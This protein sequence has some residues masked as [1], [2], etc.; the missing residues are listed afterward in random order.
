MFAFLFFFVLFFSLSPLWASH[1]IVI[2]TITRTNKNK[3]RHSTNVT[4]HAMAAWL[5]D[6][7]KMIRS[8]Y[9][10][11]THTFERIEVA[12]KKKKRRKKHE[13]WMKRHIK[14]QDDKDNRNHTYLSSS[15]TF[16][17]YIMV[18]NKS[19]YILIE[20]WGQTYH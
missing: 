20:A 6:K 4:L 8:K 1:F 5:L 7:A 18:A 13:R 15:H 17:H 16:I 11:H 2:V 9:H 3:R 14:P 10:L 12:K 19:T